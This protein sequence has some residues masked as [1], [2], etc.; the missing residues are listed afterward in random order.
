MLRQRL[1]WIALVIGIAMAVY[2][3][4]VAMI[5]RFM[6]HVAM[7]RIEQ[8][9][10]VNAMGHA[11]L[12]TAERR[13]IVRPSPDLA[14]STCLFDLSD[15]PV[16]VSVEPINAPYWSLSVFDAETNVAFVR[17]DRDANGGPVRIV[18]ALDGQAAPEDIEVVRISSTRG[19][20]LLRILVPERG[21]FE[22]IDIARGNSR[23][24]PLS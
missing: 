16:T 22:A 3:G 21:A 4:S 15:G 11:P 20:A 17:N 23:C 6:M 1:G 5:P 12:S 10:P 24:A 9:A 8:N 2:W 13:V 18:L 19:L 14:Y 7:G